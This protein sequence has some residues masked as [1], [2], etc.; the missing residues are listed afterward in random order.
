M[1]YVGLDVHKKSIAYC[2]KRADGTIEWEGSVAARRG[3]LTVWAQGLP[4][5]WTAAMEA[6]LFSDWIYDH[7]KTLGGEV[8]VGHPARMKAIS[9][10]KKKNDELD[11]RV[12]ADLLRCGLLPE[13]YM[14]P[15]PLRELRQ[16]LR[17]RHLLMRRTVQM[18]NK[19]AGLLMS[20]G[21]EYESTKLHQKGYFDGLMVAWRGKIPASARKLLEF[22]REQVETL[23]RMDDKLIQGLKAHTEIA[24]R[25]K[26]LMTIPGVGEIMALTWVLEVGPVER[27]GNIAR[28]QSFCGLTAAQKESAGKAVRGPISKQRNAHLQTV[29][30]EVAHLAPRFNERLKAVYDSQIQRGH[31]NQAAIAVARKLVAYLM[32]ADRGHE[33]R[34][35]TLTT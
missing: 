6:T 34:A 23:R 16:V 28:A 33:P 4:R 21:V 2:V 25:V 20:M 15:A 13:I 11:A 27:L 1:N 7:L 10:G 12:I 18:K 9:S 3:D 35:V 14:I 22:S 29:L 26:R 24:T 17:Y 32:A 5:P 8:K 19:I 31:P 30:I